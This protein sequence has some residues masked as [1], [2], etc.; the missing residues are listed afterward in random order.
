MADYKAVNVAKMTWRQVR[1]IEEQTGVVMSEWMDPVNRSKVW[2]VAFAYANGIPVEEA[3]DMI[4]EITMVA[5]DDE[6]DP[7]P[8]SL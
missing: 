3:L 1:E 4:V 8:A 7:T 5:S 6:A 2:P